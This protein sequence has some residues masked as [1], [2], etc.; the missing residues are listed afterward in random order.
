MTTRIVF[1]T[2]LG[3]H[4]EAT[5]HQAVWPHTASCQPLGSILSTGLEIET[6]PKPETTRVATE[7]LSSLLCLVDPCGSLWTCLSL[8]QKCKTPWDVQ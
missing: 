6:N 5:N 8:E 1:G 3:L 7:S 2:I 4:Q